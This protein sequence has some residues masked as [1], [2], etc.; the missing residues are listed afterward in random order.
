MF[1]LAKISI[2]PLH[3]NAFISLFIFRKLGFAFYG[4]Y[5]ITFP[6]LVTHIKTDALIS[7]NLPDVT[8]PSTISYLS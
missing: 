7:S 5:K 3:Y 4:E 1:S 2:C 8:K 6:I